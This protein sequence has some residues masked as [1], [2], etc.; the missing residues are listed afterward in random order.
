MPGNQPPLR[1]RDRIPRQ[2][3]NRVEQSRAE[4]VVERARR[5]LPRRLHEIVPN[6]ACE[7]CDVRADQIG[8]D[9]RA[10]G[11]SWTQRKVA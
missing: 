1:A 7:R 3:T 5:Q 6:V 8:T 9:E 4:R 10:H 11:F 2:L